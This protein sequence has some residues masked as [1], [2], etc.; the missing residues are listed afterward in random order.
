[1]TDTALDIALSYI[2]QQLAVIPVPFKQKKPA[3]EAWQTLRIAIK[4]TLRSVL[5]LR[6]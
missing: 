4:P 5:L 1:M 6:K 3:L 2:A